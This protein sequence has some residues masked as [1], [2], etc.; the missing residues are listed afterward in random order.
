MKERKSID[1]FKLS[2]FFP[3]VS[4]RFVY[5][6]IFTLDH[7]IVDYYNIHTTITKRKKKH[8]QRIFITKYT[9]KR[10][11][12]LKVHH[13]TTTTT[14]ESHIYQHTH[15]QGIYVPKNNPKTKE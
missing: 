7:S 6:F 4:F 14:P 1:I 8:T 2:G 3:L 13:Q 12:S 10:I 5:S 15:T 9:N 11:Y